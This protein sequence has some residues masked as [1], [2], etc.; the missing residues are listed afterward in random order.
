MKHDTA[1]KNNRIHNIEPD[2]EIKKAKQKT[3]KKIFFVHEAAEIS[4][5]MLL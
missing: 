2:S 3:S 5:K 4:L 1:L